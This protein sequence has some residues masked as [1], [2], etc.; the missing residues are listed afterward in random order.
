MA[1]I[2][3][4]WLANINSLV[5]LELGHN[6]LTKLQPGIFDHLT[7]LRFLTLSN[8]EGLAEYTTNAWHFCQ[9]LEKGVLNVQFDK[10]IVKDLKFD[11][12]TGRYC[13]SHE[14]G[15]DTVASYCVNNDGH[16]T[17]SGDIADLVCELWDMDFKSIVFP[18]PKDDWSWNTGVEDFYEAETN[19]YFKEVNGSPNTTREL[20]DLQLYGTKFDL[21]TIDEYVGPRAQMVTIFADTIYMSRPLGSPITSK[22][23]MRGRVVSITED[24]PM[25]MTKTQFFSFLVADQP[26]ENWAP[27]EEVVKDV[28]SVSF[29]IKKLGFVEVQKESILETNSAASSCS[30]RE[31]S[32]E[33]YENEHNT[34]PSVF[35][36][37]TQM[38]L[39]RMAVNTLAL[40]RSN[41]YLVL[42][43]A[44][45]NLMKTD[46]PEIVQDKM[47]NLIAQ[48]L[49]QDREILF[50]NRKNIPFYQ[51]PQ[52][53]SL[54]QS[55]YEKFSLYSTNENIVMSKLDISLLRLEDIKMYFL[56]AKMMRELYFELELAVLE[57]IWDSIDST[58]IWDFDASRSLEPGIQD[59]LLKVGENLIEMDMEL[60]SYRSW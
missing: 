44:K 47:I 27:A 41:G 31:F 52:M 29:S 42:E 45:H 34:P 56:E 53:G 58:W 30:P 4:F 32:V 39:Q 9:N 43:I 23:L 36:D 26:V 17:C 22:L 57:M 20:V 40:T 33:E 12:N 1:T 11:E 21:A 18:F 48:K 38:K 28:G 15:N 59:A 2:E 7:N 46:K 25:N 49:I 8:N 50:D 24:I 19:S 10:N 60:Q 51:A 35:F 14:N 5:Q 37:R 13:A 3:D 6:N 55:I 54:A 16:L